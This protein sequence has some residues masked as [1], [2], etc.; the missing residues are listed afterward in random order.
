[1]NE[2]K[3]EEKEKKIEALT[4]VGKA[5]YEIEHEQNYPGTY[6]IYIP[7]NFLM[8]LKILDTINPFKMS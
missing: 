7:I 2:R 3:K 6:K 5:T 8:I 4:Q 1:M